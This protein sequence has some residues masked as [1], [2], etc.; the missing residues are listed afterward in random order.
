MKSK[1]MSVL[2][3]EAIGRFIWALQTIRQEAKTLGV[4][5][6]IIWCILNNAT[7]RSTTPK[8]LKDH[9][10]QLQQITGQEKPFHNIC[11]SQGQS[12]RY[13]LG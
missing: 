12:E 6:S 7:T 2:V 4:V 9:I 5:K 10:R 11:L 8:G 3:K 13:S 1:E